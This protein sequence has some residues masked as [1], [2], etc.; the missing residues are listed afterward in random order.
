[1]KI[2]KAYKFRIYPNKEQQSIFEQ[3]FGVYRFVY[4]TVLDYK[5]NS[6]KRGIKYTAYDAIK[7]FTLIAKESPLL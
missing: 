1:M 5:I 3:Y 2:N 4:N 7:D 6:Y